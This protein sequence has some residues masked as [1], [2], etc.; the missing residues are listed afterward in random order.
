[1]PSA[2]FR[3][4]VNAGHECRVLCESWGREAYYVDG[5]LLFTRWSAA[6]R[7]TRKFTACGHQLRIDIAVRSSRVDAKAYV[8]G[9][10]VADDLFA[11]LNQRLARLA[12]VRVEHSAALRAVGWVLTAAVLV[13][14]LRIFNL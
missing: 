12:L 5:K 7:G 1:M 10:L 3:F 9:L 4:G 13:G 11:E 2:S 6:V 8:D 14:V